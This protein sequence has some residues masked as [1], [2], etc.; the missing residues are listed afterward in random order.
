MSALLSTKNSLEHSIALLVFICFSLLGLVIYSGYSVIFDTSYN[1]IRALEIGIL[2]LISLSSLFTKTN[3]YVLNKESFYLICLLTFFGFISALY[4]SKYPIRAFRDWS[5]YCLI[6]ISIINLAYLIHV[7]DKYSTIAFTVLAV[8]PLLFILYFIFQILFSYFLTGTPKD[9]V[10]ESWQSHFGLPRIFGDTILPVIFMLAALISTTRNPKYRIYLMALCICA[11]TLL[12]FSGG[13][14]V[15]ISLLT[16][17]I[18]G[19]IFIKAHRRHITYFFINIIISGIISH[20]LTYILSNGL[21]GAQF[22]RIDDSGRGPIINKALHQVSEN[23]LL[24]IGPAQFYSTTNLILVSHPHNFFLQILVEWGVI[25]F[26]FFLAL[27]IGFLIKTTA[28]IRKSNNSFDFFIFL[29]FIAFLIN[30]NFNGS[31]IYSGS[32]VYGLFITSFL[33]SKLIK[34]THSYHYKN[35]I[36]KVLSVSILLFLL[37][38]T[39]ISLNC[40]YNSQNTSIHQVYG[41]RFWMNDSPP[42]DNICISSKYLQH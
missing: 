27:I 36:L 42:N 8:S 21:T 20:L 26:F 25:S 31:H 32:Q 41:P 28:M 35:K 24:G 19:S 5:L 17:S 29:G 13:R 1:D 2:F 16:S 30:S 10:I 3:H 22:L 11:T 4:Q 9:M 6:I 18:L 12:I 14:G 39:Y 7:Y 37:S 38:T 23:F 40:A 15:I 33:C 34:T